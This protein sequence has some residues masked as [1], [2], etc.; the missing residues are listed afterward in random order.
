[1]MEQIQSE[2]GINRRGMILKLITSLKQICNHPANYLKNQDFSYDLSGKTKKVFAITE[3][4]LEANEK[5]LIFT[6][7]KEMGDIL[8]QIIADECNTEPSFF[9][10]SCSGSSVSLV[11]SLPSAFRVARRPQRSPQHR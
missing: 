2:S 4:I 10:S 11:L 5:V 6:Q 7:Y 9:H 8:T 1:M 3:L